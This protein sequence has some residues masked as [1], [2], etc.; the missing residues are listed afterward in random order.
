MQGLETKLLAKKSDLHRVAKKLL[1]KL[2][3]LPTAERPEKG[4][5]RIEKNNALRANYSNQS[6]PTNAVPGEELQKLSADLSPDHHA[7]YK[8]RLSIRCNGIYLRTL[9]S[10]HH[11]ASIS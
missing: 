10:D 5:E 2:E 6:K 3:M 1:R 7:A 11:E 9:S 8:R 4:E